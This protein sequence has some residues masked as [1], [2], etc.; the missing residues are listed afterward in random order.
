MLLVAVK[1]RQLQDGHVTQGANFP[2][3]QPFNEAF[4]VKGVLAWTYTQL[5]LGL[6]FF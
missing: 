2:H 6:E 4:S 1:L 5:I 3:F